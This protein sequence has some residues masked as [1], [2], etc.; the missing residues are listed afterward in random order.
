MNPCP[1]CLATGPCLL[2]CGMGDWDAPTYVN[3][4]RMRDRFRRHAPARV[5]AAHPTPTYAM[6]I[7][8]RSAVA[9]KE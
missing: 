5:R 8:I 4:A 7:V 9:T 6:T 1:R 3:I 2:G